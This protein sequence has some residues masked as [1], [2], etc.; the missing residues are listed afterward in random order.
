MTDHLVFVTSDVSRSVRDLASLLGVTA[1]FGGRHPAW[2]T[3]NA[4]LSHGGTAYLEI[5][6][7]DGSA[8]D[9][10]RPR[11]FGMDRQDSASLRTWVARS[12]DLKRT[13]STAA[14]EGVDLGDV[15]PGS[16]TTPDGLVLKWKMTDLTKERRDGIVPYFIA[17]GRTPHP[18][19][20]APQGCL[21]VGLKAFHPEA[22]QIANVLMRLGIEMNIERGPVGFEALIQTPKG[23]VTLR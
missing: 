7:P 3:Q 15:L 11:P 17:W 4:V 9:P 12:D 8:S 20:T 19:T 13:V 22:E 23:L 5:M 21:L 6:G 1:A 16:R 14:A 10:V 2:R 18:G